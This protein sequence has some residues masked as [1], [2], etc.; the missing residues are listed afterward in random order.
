MFT[1]YTFN[2]VKYLIRLKY[3]V[4]HKAVLSYIIL[5][6]SIQIRII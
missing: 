2:Q 1:C 6:P 3:K 4:K 5:Q